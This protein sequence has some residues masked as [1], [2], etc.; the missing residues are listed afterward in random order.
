MSQPAGGEPVQ[1]QRT[2]AAPVARAFQAFTEQIGQWWPPSYR[3]GGSEGS[4]VLI[5]PGVGRRWYERPTDGP[6]C[7]WG[8]TLAWDPPHRLDLSWQITPDFGPE[9]DPEK[10]SRIEVRFEPDGPDRTAVTLVHSA[11]ERHGEGG[12]AMRGAVA[13]AWPGIMDTYAKVAAE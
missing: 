3:L 7:D 1:V 5:E 6:E 10:A 8:R 2:V 9:P 11:F 4:P 13:T 12:P